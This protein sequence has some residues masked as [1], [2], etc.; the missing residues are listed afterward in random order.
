MYFHEKLINQVI[1]FNTHY[2]DLYFY[3][4]KMPAFR[5]FAVKMIACFAFHRQ[6]VEP[7]KNPYTEKKP[8]Y[9]SSILKL[10]FLKNLGLI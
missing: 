2:K 3:L 7:L 8:K 9:N 4:M 5:F 6:Q 1:K 10:I